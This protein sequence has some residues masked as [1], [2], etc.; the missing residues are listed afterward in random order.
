MDSDL[1]DRVVDALHRVGLR[2]DLENTSPTKHGGVMTVD[3][4]SVDGG[5]KEIA[6]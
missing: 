3:G 2:R 5:N 6:R 4:E 1:L